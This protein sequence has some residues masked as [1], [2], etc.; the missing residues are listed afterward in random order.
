MA[1]ILGKLKLMRE[2]AGEVDEVR[3]DFSLGPVWG[4]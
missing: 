1:A 3:V 2:T 4:L